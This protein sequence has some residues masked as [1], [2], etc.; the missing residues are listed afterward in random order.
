MFS[1]SDF[2][3]ALG[4]ATPTL[5]PAQPGASVTRQPAPRYCDAHVLPPQVRAPYERLL[6]ARHVL[7]LAGDE[8]AAQGLPRLAAGARLASATC[9]HI[10]SAWL[11]AHGVVPHEPTVGAPARD[12]EGQ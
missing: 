7:A 11:E 6:D 5:A 3:P 2:G 4:A 9:E 10:A 12:R 1:A 8:L